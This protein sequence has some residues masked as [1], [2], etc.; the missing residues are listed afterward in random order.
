VRI[1][2]T[3][4]DGVW[5]VDSTGPSGRQYTREFDTVDEALAFIERIEQYWTET[6]K[7]EEE[8]RHGLSK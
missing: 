7:K 3:V 6:R 2:T 8:G 5:R 4:V 1:T